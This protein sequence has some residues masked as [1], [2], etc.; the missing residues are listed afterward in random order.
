MKA[1]CF[2][3]DDRRMG[4][5]RGVCA[6]GERLEEAGCLDVGAGDDEEG[7]VDLVREDLGVFELRADSGCPLD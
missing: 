1:F 3:E 6:G 5:L 7:S 4:R 2:D